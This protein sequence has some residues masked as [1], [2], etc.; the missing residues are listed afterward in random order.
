[1]FFWMLD[2]ASRAKRPT[3]VHQARE[4]PPP[5]P[6]DP[7][8]SSGEHAVNTVV[9]SASSFRVH[10]SRSGILQDPSQRCHLLLKR[11]ELA[12]SEFTRMRQMMDSLLTH[13]APPDYGSQ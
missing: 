2:S 9:Y 7:P 5:E 13:Y 6:P 1:M 8:K 4:A 3:V 11:Q 10:L 12:K